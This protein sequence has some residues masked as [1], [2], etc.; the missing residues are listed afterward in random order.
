MEVQEEENKKT[1]EEMQTEVA[2]DPPETT[3]EIPGLKE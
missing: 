2:Q 3:E 1:G